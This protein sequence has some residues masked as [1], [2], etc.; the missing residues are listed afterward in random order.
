MDIKSGYSQVVSGLLYNSDLHA[1]K[2]GCA[3]QNGEP[4]Y[5]EASNVVRLCW[6]IPL[7]VNHKVFYDNFSSRISL[8][9]YLVKKGLHSAATVCTNSLADN[10]PLTGKQ[11]K[12]CGIEGLWHRRQQLLMV[13][14]FMQFCGMTIGWCHW[15]PCIV[16]C[17][18]S[19]NLGDSS[20]MKQYEKRRTVLL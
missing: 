3:M 1:G 18:K 9:T 10:K 15:F 12:K 13:W 5:G 14:Q 16:K 11:M 6:H 7:A 19:Q 8:L 2:D 17:N 4:D 20:N